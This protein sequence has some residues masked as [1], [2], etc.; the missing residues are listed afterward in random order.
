[1]ALLISFIPPLFL[2]EWGDWILRAVMFIVISCPCA[3]VVSVPL[4]FFGAL[5]GASRSGILVK[6]SNYLEVLASVDTVVFDKTGTL[7]KGAF[8]VVDICPAKGVSKERLLEVAAICEKHSSHPIGEAIKAICT[9]STADQGR[10]ETVA[11]KG[12]RCVIGDR[13]L[14]A[15]NRTLLTE[16]GFNPP[17]I[18]SPATVVYVADGDYLGFLLISDSIKENAENAEE[19]PAEE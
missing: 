11:G 4:A 8:E 14:L 13:V 5:G 12:V 19:A 17:E 15:G 1:M 9:V 10:Y 3:L 6:G 18:T 2:G 7:T 16:S